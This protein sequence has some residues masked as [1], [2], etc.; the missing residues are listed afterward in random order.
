MW[1]EGKSWLSIAKVILM[2][3]KATDQRGFFIP[4]STPH[5]MAST[6]ESIKITNRYLLKNQSLKSGL[7]VAG[8]V[9]LSYF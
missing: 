8:I 7:S 1:P 5:Y 2:G 4:Q 9:Y 6:M 3:I